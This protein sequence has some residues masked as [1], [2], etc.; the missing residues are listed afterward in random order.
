MLPRRVLF[1]SGHFPNTLKSCSHLEST[2]RH[3]VILFSLRHS[4]KTWGIY[5]ILFLS[6]SKKHQFG[7][8]LKLPESPLQASA[9]AAAGPGTAS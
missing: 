5:F 3:G 9:G 2:E 1:L 6:W 4:S 8:M 7:Y